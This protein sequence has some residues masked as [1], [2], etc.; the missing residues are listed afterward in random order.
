MPYFNDYLSQAIYNITKDPGVN[1]P[2][3]GSKSYNG[4]HTLVE[5]PETRKIDLGLSGLKPITV[6]ASTYLLTE[7]NNGGVY[8]SSQNSVESHTY[9]VKYSEEYARH[10]G[11]LPKKDAIRKRPGAEPRPEVPLNLDEIIQRHV[12]GWVR[13]D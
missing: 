1:Y 11:H 10:L 9:F 8:L 3:C 13:R 7:D 4:R 12:I 6:G 5:I 2:K